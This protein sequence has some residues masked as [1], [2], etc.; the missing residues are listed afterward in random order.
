MAL[1]IASLNSGSNGNCYYIGNYSEA[2]LIDAGLSCRETE[3]RMA[4][5]GLYIKKVKAIFISHE[6]TDHT[7]GVEVLSRRHKIPVYLTGRT[8]QNSR[9]QLE[10][11]LVRSFDSYNPVIIGSLLVNPFP[12]LHDAAE[13]HSF[14]ISDGST[15]IGVLTDIGKACE[16]VIHNFRQCHAAF[17]E[18]NYDEVML[19]EGRY[20]PFLKQRIKSDHGHLSNRQAFELFATHR[21]VTLSHLLLSHLS[22]DNNDPGRVLDLFSK[23]AGNTHISIASRHQETEV[24]TITGDG[25]AN[26]LDFQVNPTWVPQQMTLF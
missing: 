9:L 13:P 6:H 16:H 2:V 14:I 22:Q 24:F 26:L 15:N 21:P 5:I 7:R 17:L 4:R 1:N 3:M 8:L 20:P 25:A 11:D 18:A 19:D 10:P 23:A 12:K